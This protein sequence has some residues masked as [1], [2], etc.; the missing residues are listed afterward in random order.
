MKQIPNIINHINNSENRQNNNQNSAI[1][2]NTIKNALLKV[3]PSELD[4]AKIETETDGNCLIYS[5]LKTLN[6]P[7]SY[8]KEFR[9]L[10]ANKTR[11]QNIDKKILE[12]LNFNNIEDYLKYIQIDKA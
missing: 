8:H 11:E 5:I 1:E 10:I 12:A 9:E 4:I 6:I 2:P 3:T 7:I